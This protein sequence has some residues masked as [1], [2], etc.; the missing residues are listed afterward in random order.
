MI[1]QAETLIEYGYLPLDLKL[2]SN[3]PILAACDECGKVRETT[4]NAYRSLCISCAEKG[5]IFSKETKLLLS[6]N[7][8]DVKGDKHPRWLGGISYGLY[9][10]KFNESY[11]QLIRNRFDNRCFWCNMTTEENGVALSVHHV[12]YNKNCGCDETKC[13]C[14]PL[15]VRCHM[16]SNGDRIGWREKIMK[17]LELPGIP[18]E[19]QNGKDEGDIR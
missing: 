16:K 15:C 10:K 18:M 17:K 14:V 7:H 6:K 8:V 11:K 1:L 4:K 12:N 3:K 9:C 2:K 13:I 5:K 19:D